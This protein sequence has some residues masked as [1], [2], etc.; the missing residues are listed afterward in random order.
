LLFFC[1]IKN[2]IKKG[3]D[4]I[5][6]LVGLLA[7]GSISSFAGTYQYNC[8]SI[9]EVDPQPNL[10]LELRTSFHTFDP[11]KINSERSTRVSS[12]NRNYF[13]DKSITDKY[14]VFSEVVAFF[15]DSKLFQFYEVANSN[16]TYMFNHSFPIGDTDDYAFL[17][18]KDG[19]SYGF[20]NCGFIDNE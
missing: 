7:L 6:L 20:Y 19:Q 18:V 16:K 9:H 12:N 5:K 8:K 14:G 2:K 4:M 3:K 10:L 13:A 11:R 17:V 15:K 1:V